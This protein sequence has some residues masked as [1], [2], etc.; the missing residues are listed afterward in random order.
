MKLSD[1]V[2]HDG[3]GLAQLI[4]AKEV[5]SAEV[6][7]AAGQ[8]I[9]ALNPQINAVIEQWP[10][11]TPL[12]ENQSGIFAGTPFLIKDV[13]ISM[14]GKRVELGSRLAAG[15]VA[16]ADSNLMRHF[17]R[18]GLITL[19]R[20]TSP[21]MAFSTTTESV[22]NGPTCNPWNVSRSAG[23]SSGGAAAAVAAGM[24][25]LAHATD[26]AGSIRVPA[27]CNGLF[28]LK[29]T[30]GRVS[31]G[32]YMDEVFNGFGVQSCVSRSVRDSAALLDA[33]NLADY[34]D[35]YFTPP[36]SDSFL[37]DVTRP[38]GRLR[39][40]L[41]MQAHDGQRPTTEVE[42]A[43]LATAKL[44]EDL[45][46]HVDIGS[47]DLGVSWDQFVFANAQIWCAN[48]VGWAD[49]LAASGKRNVDAT[50]L[51][52][53]TLACY[54]YG[55]RASAVD[56]VSALDIRNSVTRS[57][58]ACLQKYD[59]LL[60]PTLPDVAL[61]LGAYAQGSET[62]DGL[63]W[64]GRVFRHSPYT[65]IINVAGIPAMSVPCGWDNVGLPIGAQFVA[66]YGCDSTLF[67]LAGQLERTAPWTNR[68]PPVWAG[69]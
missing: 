45:G 12:L 4:A 66:G 58:A 52:A 8:A 9:T 18:S 38:P 51:E 21:E 59:V 54:E 35:P 13:A 50:T 31:N 62:M 67:R 29:S 56:Y 57:V 20:T 44:C 64:T 46:H 34:G 36:P 39:I 61:P 5:T 42:R 32:P 48:L 49:S 68:T 1:Y 17:R 53:A 47:F 69:N 3:L 60:T 55:R 33:I 23:G 15:N 7:Q 63:E 65:P 43:I 41:I 30:R 22:F 37:S 6:A 27:S 26:A 28:G 24:V 14:E 40:G 2:Q 10:A 25:P 19:G 11:D 16:G